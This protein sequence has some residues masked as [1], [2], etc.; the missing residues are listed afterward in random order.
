MRVLQGGHD[1]PAEKLTKRFPRTMKNLARAI[2]KL[3]HVLVFDN[4]DLR[5]PFRK[6]A[7]FHDGKAI[8]LN[9]PMP[10]WLPLRRRK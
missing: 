3:P 5:H 7:E 4:S 2:R 6:V 8:S 10:A 1:V 9:E